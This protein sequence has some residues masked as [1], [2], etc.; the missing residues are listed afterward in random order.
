MGG[1]A[2]PASI[3][4]SDAAADGLF[5]E[6]SASMTAPWAITLMRALGETC[7]NQ[8]GN[9]KTKLTNAMTAC[10][11]NRCCWM[12]GRGTAS[13]RVPMATTK[14]PSHAKPTAS[15]KLLMMLRMAFSRLT[16]AFTP[17][18]ILSCIAAARVS[19]AICCSFS[20]AMCC[21]SCGG[22]SLPRP[23]KQHILFWS[24]VGVAR[25]NGI[26]SG[27]GGGCSTVP[28]VPA[29]LSNKM[30]ETIAKAVRRNA[31]TISTK[32]SLQLT[33]RLPA[34]ERQSRFRSQLAVMALV[35]R[36]LLIQRS[37][38]GTWSS[39]SCAAVSSLS[40][41]AVMT[42]TPAKQK[43]TLPVNKTIPKASKCAVWFSAAAEK[44][45]FMNN[46]AITKLDTM[47]HAS[48]SASIAA[49]IH[50][51]SEPSSSPSESCASSS[52]SCAARLDRRLFNTIRKTTNPTNMPIAATACHSTPGSELQLAPTAAMPANAVMWPEISLAARR[53]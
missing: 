3:L 11:M 37:I 2:P 7:F 27:G 35:V 51:S 26:G 41:R 48:S 24:R 19:I 32:W 29:N 52:S 21:S 1:N 43:M 6:L 30:M 4:R 9:I 47:Q 50:A 45:T 12:I 40:M 31:E 18:V 42:P 20:I 16:D 33:R 22:G 39:L 44:T 23:S 38:I 53:H 8:T 36:R 28:N 17:F 13:T 25:K 14:A 49:S 5:A 10:A 46:F 34:R 15:A